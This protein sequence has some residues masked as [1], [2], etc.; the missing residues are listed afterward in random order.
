MGDALLPSVSS[1]GD[2]SGRANWAA[3]PLSFTPTQNILGRF[4]SLKI[5]YC[6][7][8]YNSVSSAAMDLPRDLI[9]T[10]AAIKLIGI[11][12]TTMRNLLRDNVLPYF[13]DPLDKRKKLVS[14]SAVLSLRIPSAEAA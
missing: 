4:P 6:I 1:V 10:T 14:K 7:N 8:L 12:P 3:L 13:P 2:E 11:S 5:S 9:T